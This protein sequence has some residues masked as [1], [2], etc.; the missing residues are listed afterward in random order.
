MSINLLNTYISGAAGN[1]VGFYAYRTTNLCYFNHETIVFD[2]TS[3][4]QGGVGNLGVYNNRDGIFEPSVTG[5]YVFSWTV[6]AP[7]DG[8]RFVT[9]LIINGIVKGV[10]ASGPDI[11]VS[12]SGTGDPPPQKRAT[13]GSGV[14]PATAVVVAQVDAGYRCF[15]R[16][17]HSTG[18]CTYVL[19]E[20]TTALST[21]SAWRLH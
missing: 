18:A 15:I 21:F 19:S 16:V 11:S 9:E 3:I 10:I 6:A 13:E 2:M 12:S 20:R 14:H 7:K 1:N 8:H 17:R 5:V 4:D